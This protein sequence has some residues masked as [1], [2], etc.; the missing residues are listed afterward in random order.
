MKKIVK[1]IRECILELKRVS[2]PSKEE[3][4]ASTKTVVISVLFISLLLGVLDY[5]LF[6]ALNILL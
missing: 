1:F 2:W 3:V 5:L 6:N 4:I